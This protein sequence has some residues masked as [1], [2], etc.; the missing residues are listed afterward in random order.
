MKDKKNATKVNTD[1]PFKFQLDSAISF[2]SKA[3]PVI[4]ILKERKSS[5]EDSMLSLSISQWA[6]QPIP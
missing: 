2:L 3:C 1:D 4:N 6:V 5:P